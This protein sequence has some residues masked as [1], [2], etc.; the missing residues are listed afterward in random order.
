[1]TCPI[2]QPKPDPILGNLRDIDTHAPVQSLMR[3][4]KTYGPVFQLTLP[5]AKGRR[6]FVSSHELADELFDESR[7][8]KKVH[9]SLEQIR[10]FAGDGLFTAHT[11]EPNW[12]SAHR[13][14][15][16]AFGPLPIREMFPEMYDVADQLLL[17]WE[18]FGEDTVIDV[19]D[20][21]TR[22]TLD[23]IALCAFDYRFNS[24][25]QNELHPFVG[26][27]VDALA[28]AGA[29]ALFCHPS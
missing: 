2:P 28:E 20:N 18:R 8:D 22:L 27:M 15:M 14:L 12:E 23:T 25:Y 11:D 29:A 5:G 19:A 6:I 24:F 3:L 9:A 7:F 16:P 4:A 1:M 17:R 10:D 26:A 13:I 21:M